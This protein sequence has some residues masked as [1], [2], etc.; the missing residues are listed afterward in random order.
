MEKNCIDCG[1]PFESTNGQS[2]RC[3]LCRDKATKKSKLEWKRRNQPPKSGGRVATTLADPVVLKNCRWCKKVFTPGQ[4]ATAY[5]CDTCREAGEARIK[6]KSY[7]RH[8]NRK[9][10][11]TKSP[12]KIESH[13]FGTFN[14]ARKNV[15][16]EIL[17][18]RR[19]KSPNLNELPFKYVDPKMRSVYFFAT[20]EKL[21]KFLQK[22]A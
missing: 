17:K 10:L 8:K 14:R 18:E 16:G 20:P 22:Q 6:A 12:V 7:S 13:T 21:Q 1:T 5:C 15:D 3:L 2:K 19:I 4:K 9:M 11:E